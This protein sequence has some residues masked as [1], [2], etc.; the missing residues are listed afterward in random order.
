MEIMW[1]K[2]SERIGEWTGTEG[3]RK[4][5]QIRLNNDRRMKRLRNEK[6]NIERGEA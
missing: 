6:H 1:S 5:R 3:G 4:E 2:I